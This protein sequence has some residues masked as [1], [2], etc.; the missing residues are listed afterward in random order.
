MKHACF[1]F[2]G[3]LNDFLPLLS[4]GVTFA[5][6]FQGRP[7]VK[8]VIES[9]GVPHTEVDLILANGAFVDFSTLL[10]DGDRISVYPTFTS[11][12]TSSL[13]RVRAALPSERCFVLD[14]HLGRLATYLR[15]LGFDSLYG[16]YCKDEELARLSRDQ[17]RVLLTRDRGLLERGIVTYGYYVREDHPREQLLEILWHFDLAGSIS[18]FSRCMRCN[19]PLQPVPKE[20]INDRLQPTTQQLYDRFHTCPCCERVYWKGAHYRRMQQLIE[21]VMKPITGRARTTASE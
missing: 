1:R 5:H 3:E 13:R 11:L 18:P 9:V 14:T 17:H 7:S 2:Y 19:T 6:R 12:D 16:N 15:M 4:R 10:Q 21:Q 20:Q 8:D